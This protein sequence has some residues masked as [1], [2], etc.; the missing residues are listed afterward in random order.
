MRSYVG[1]LVA[2]SEDVAGAVVSNRVAM[3]PGLS[4]QAVAVKLQVCGATVGKRRLVEHRLDGLP[5][6][7]RTGVPRTITDEHVEEVETATRET[8]PKNLTQWS[9]RCMA[10]VTGFS[11]MAVVRIWK[12]IGVPPHRTRTFKLSVDPQFIDKVRDIVG[13]Y[14]DPPDR[15][16]VLCINEKSQVQALDRTQLLLLLS[17][18]IPAQRTHDYVRHGTISLFSRLNVAIGD[19]SEISFPA[20]LIRRFCKKTESNCMSLWITMPPPNS[21]GLR[22]H[23]HFTPT[24]ASWLNQVD[25]LSAEITTK[26]IRCGAFRSVRHFEQA[27]ADYIEEYNVTLQP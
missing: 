15:A 7:P 8:T 5:D 1:S 10:A 3:C 21:D 25:R 23:V 26:R 24:S 4:N 16:L 18:G 6:G 2:V 17:S 9:T 13:L 20:K 22:Y 11:Q 14:L 19:R 12:A 27:I